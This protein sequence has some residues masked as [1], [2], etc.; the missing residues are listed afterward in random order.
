[1]YPRTQLLLFP[2]ISI[3][4][5]SH[6]FPPLFLFHPSSLF[7]LSNTLG[8]VSALLAPIL[9]AN[10]SPMH[11]SLVPLPPEK[12]LPYILFHLLSLHFPA[13][14]P[15]FLLSPAPQASPGVPAPCPPT[16][17]A[18]MPA[19]LQD[20]MAQAWRKQRKI[21]P[22]TAQCGNGKRFK[23]RANNSEPKVLHVSS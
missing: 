15:P 5:H 7:Q 21:S 3:H 14:T 8:S 20:A 17:H 12:T 19:F 4:S 10:S 13:P 22:C 16:L 9:P 18:V 6:Q 2:C 23:Q 11:H 1:M